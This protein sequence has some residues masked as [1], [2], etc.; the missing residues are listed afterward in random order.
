MCEFLAVGCLG[1]AFGRATTACACTVVRICRGGEIQVVG[2]IP[3]V[4]LRCR[5]WQ[6]D[7]QVRGLLF[8]GFMYDSL[9]QCNPSR[10]T[11]H[12]KW[13]WCKSTT[14]HRQSCSFPSEIHA[15]RAQRRTSSFDDVCGRFSTS[16]A[17]ARVS[18]SRR[19]APSFRADGMP[20]T[21]ARRAKHVARALHVVLRSSP[22]RA[23]PRGWTCE[24]KRTC[25]DALRRSHRGNSHETCDARTRRMWTSRNVCG[26]ASCR[27]VRV[28]CVC[29]REV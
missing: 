27:M 5:C 26:G 16:A 21:R 20:H 18:P 3:C 12:A 28:A 22:T 19:V 2:L 1:R 25:V 4:W 14:T 9:R 6:S 24:C 11:H 29:T 8:L 13:S 15:N 10:F 17:H 7:D 23:R